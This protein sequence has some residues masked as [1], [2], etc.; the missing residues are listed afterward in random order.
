LDDGEDESADFREQAAVVPKAWAQN[1]RNR[2]CE[3]KIEGLS[4]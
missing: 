3:V 2:L 1:S 4:G